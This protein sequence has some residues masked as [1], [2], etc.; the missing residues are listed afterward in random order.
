MV[1]C[2]RN[3]APLHSYH[4]VMMKKF[5]ANIIFRPVGV[6]DRQGLGSEHIGYLTEFLKKL[7]FIF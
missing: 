6:T 7:F 3:K 2:D 4:F 5:S 1:F